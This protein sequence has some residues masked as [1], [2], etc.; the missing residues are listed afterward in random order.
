M[1]EKYDIYD[2][3]GNPIGIAKTKSQTHKKG[4]WHRSFHCWIIF[5]DKAG[6]GFIILQR[7]SKK[8]EH[9]PNRLDV[10]VA[11]HYQ[12]GEGVE[13]GLRE[14]K[15]ELGVNIL[16]DKLIPLGQRV[17]VDEFNP[18]FINHEFQDVFF[19]IDNRNLKEYKISDDEVSGLVAISLDEGLALFSHAISSVLAKGCLFDSSGRTREKKILISTDDFIPSLDNYYYKIMILAQRALNNERYLLI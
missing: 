8:K 9:W 16:I 18:R 12:A 5:K 17:C 7:R 6:K 3:T 2:G 10:S 11:G 13:G 15:E 19:L 1:E 14:F 4:L